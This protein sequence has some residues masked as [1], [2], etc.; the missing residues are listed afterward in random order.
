MSRQVT[1]KEAQQQQVQGQQQYA[2]DTETQEHHASANAQVWLYLL[3]SSQSGLVVERCGIRILLP[4]CLLT[5]LRLQ[6]ILVYVYVF[7]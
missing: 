5:A 4:N 6:R 3:V 1:K 2:R 7:L